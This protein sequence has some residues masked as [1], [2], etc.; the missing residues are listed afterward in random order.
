VIGSSIEWSDLDVMR[1]GEPVVMIEIVRITARYH[2]R[3][4]VCWRL[5]AIQAISL[6]CNGNSSGLSL[7][8]GTVGSFVDLLFF[9]R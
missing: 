5:Q 8:L 6:A 7:Q 1:E 2:S 4:L 3:S 9:A